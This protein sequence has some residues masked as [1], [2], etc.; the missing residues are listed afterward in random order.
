MASAATKAVLTLGVFAI[1]AGLGVGLKQGWLPVELLAPPAGVLREDAPSGGIEA[2][3]VTGTQADLAQQPEPDPSLLEPQGE[4][5]VFVAETEHAPPLRKVVRVES[6]PA[7][8]VRGAARSLPIEEDEEPPPSG[9][10][11]AQ[12]EQPAPT[13]KPTAPASKD[14]GFAETLAA[15][16][17]HLEQDEWLAAHKEL[18]R[19]YWAEPERRAEIMDRINHTAQ[20]IFFSPQPHFID[21]HV[22]SAGDRLQTIASQYKLSWEFVAQLNQI[23]PKR[24]RDG[25]K[26]KVI[27]GPFSAVVELNDFSMTVHLQGYYV[28]RYQVGI[29]KDGASP[30]GKHT[31][32]DKVVNPQYTAPDGKVIS[33]DDPA[34]PLGERWINLGNSYGI[35]GT[36]EPDSIGKAASRGCIRLGDDDVVEVYNFLING[37]EVVIR[38]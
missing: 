28:K 10:R 33:G 20:A 37:S 6:Q 15:V 34:N 9:I 29:G 36:I 18:S 30:M 2:H 5:P 26:L 21:P 25:Q 23:D 32:I 1:G 11:Q 38:P 27:R 24:I 17:A 35:H 22:V 12:F 14:K 3:A 13:V 19:L 31:V 16:E 7:E 8:V 4:P